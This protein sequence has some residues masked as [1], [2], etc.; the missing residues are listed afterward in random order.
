MYKYNEGWNTPLKFDISHEVSYLAQ[1]SIKVYI[2]NQTKGD[3]MKNNQNNPNSNANEFQKKVE[4]AVAAAMPKMGI[5]SIAIAMLKGQA[6]EC[7]DYFAKGTYSKKEFFK[8]DL[9][10]GSALKETVKPMLPRAVNMLSGFVTIAIGALQVTSG[11]TYLAADALYAV[12]AIPSISV[13]RGITEIKER[14]K[15][16]PAEAAAA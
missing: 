15:K 5:S 3:S 7:R 1:A 8:R 10:Y 12:A 13:D 16:E 11:A 6:P 2:F 9:A 14:T 4:E